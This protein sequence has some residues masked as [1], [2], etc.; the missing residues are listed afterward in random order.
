M[1]YLVLKDEP[2]SAYTLRTHSGLVSLLRLAACKWEL[3]QITV[4]TTGSIARDPCYI[5]QERESQPYLDNPDI[6]FAH[7]LQSLE[8]APQ[9]A[10]THETRPRKE[11]EVA[12]QSTLRGPQ[13]YCELL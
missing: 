9:Q 3:A 8:V 2:V 11:L 13:F 5:G 10:E 6:L 12:M 1:V 7:C 4:Y